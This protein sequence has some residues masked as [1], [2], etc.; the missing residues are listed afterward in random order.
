MKDSDLMVLL[1]ICG[2][3]SCGTPQENKEKDKTVAEYSEGDSPI[4]GN[5]VAPKK[6]VAHIGAASGSN[7]KGEITFLYEGDKVTMKVEV[8]GLPAGTH[9]IHLHENGDCS[10]ED[11]KS[12]G[13]HWN[14]MDKDHGKIGND[15]PYHKGD[16]GN[17]E[18]GEDGKVTLTFF[19]D[20]WCVGCGNESKDVIGKSVIIH[21]GE[22]DF[23]SQPSG[24]A[25][26]RIGCGVIE[27]E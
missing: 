8:E 2:C 27:Q 4:I 21:A 9:A 7:V 17:L 13:G 19:T 1:V 11:G 22:D 10:A 15:G 5:A 6:A 26:K 24:N 16:I 20:E 25:G 18:T 12:A 14:P 3:M 23:T